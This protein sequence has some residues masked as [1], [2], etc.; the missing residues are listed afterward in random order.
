MTGRAHR[1][2]RA[3]AALLGAGEHPRGE[4]ACVDELQRPVG[5]AWG[6][7]TPAALKPPQPPR[8]PADVLVGSE[9]QPGAG[10]QRAV[11]EG[12]HTAISAP[13]FAAA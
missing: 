11:T 1:V 2:E 7:D 9:D 8:Q 12:P 3:A 5:R 4:I 10:E 13:R 6:E